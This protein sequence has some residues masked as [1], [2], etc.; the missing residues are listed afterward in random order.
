MS[1]AKSG[2]T[3]L[4]RADPYLEWGY[5]T[6]FEY[7]FRDPTSPFHPTARSRH[8]KS[9]GL[10]V[11]WR[12]MG[13]AAEA[14]KVARSLKIAVP[15]IFFA[16]GEDAGPKRGRKVWTLT[17]PMAVLTRFLT[18]IEPLVEQIE[19]A[20]PVTAGP[21]A[22]DLAPAKSKANVLAAVLDDGCSFANDRFRNA[23]GTRVLSLWNQDVDAPGPSPTGLAYGGR[24]SKADLDTF[25]PGAL[26]SQDQAYRDAGLI[27]LRRPASHGTHVMDLLAGSED[28]DIVFVQFPQSGIDDPTGLWLKRFALEGLLYVVDQAGPK[29]KTIVANVSWGPQT[30]SHDGSSPLEVAI[31]ALIVEQKSLPKP[32][33]L[34]ISLPSGNSYESQA[35]ARVNYRDGGSFEWMV[36]PDGET[37][38][39]IELWWPKTVAPANARLRV[40][41]PFGP[42]LDIVAGVKNPT[43]GSWWAGIK[44]VGTSTRGLVVVHPT[45]G[46]GAPAKRGRHGRW[47]IEILATPAGPPK[48]VEVYLARAS[49]NMGA[50]RRATPSYLTDGPLED[51]RFVAP[52]HRYDEVS[53]SA[54]RRQGTLNGLAT[55]TH[56]RVAGGYV[57]DTFG[58]A[59]YTS[60][61]GT[62]GNRLQ[63]D[64]ACVTDRSSVRPGLRASG[65][66]S[67][68]KAILIGTST[69]APQLGRQ[70]V[71][72]SMIVF[73]PIPYD[74]LRV[75]DGCL[76][77]ADDLDLRS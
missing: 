35:H 67:G 18:A 39:F 25:F 46:L 58:C 55:S 56:T 59:P 4:E 6:D 38:A 71:K 53:G 34:I 68:T 24:W 64:Y 10:L 11:Q 13:A 3:F 42:A 37:P 76:W 9:V 21:V 12:S 31:E 69:A 45:G 36:P 66:R 22:P 72:A 33:E 77:P 49:H 5:D 27:G 73:D 74:P 17:V 43:G 60:S 2:P 30:G 14:A 61:G 15:G 28:W 63:P 20:A 44:N 50:R 51:S 54:I 62:R 32:R 40:K 75:G 48:N 23:T 70:I 7:L 1:E 65:V 26:R 47:S 19:L 16:K 8:G 41:P 29:T 57:F 52:A